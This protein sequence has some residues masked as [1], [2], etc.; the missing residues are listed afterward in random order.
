MDTNVVKFVFFTI[1]LFYDLR[2]INYM[3]TLF[4]AISNK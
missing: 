3:K 1:N 2:Q 4:T